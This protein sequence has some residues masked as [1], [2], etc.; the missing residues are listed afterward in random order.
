MALTQASVEQANSQVEAL[1]STIITEGVEEG[2]VSL[3]QGSHC[4]ELEQPG[5]FSIHI[6]RMW[7]LHSVKSATTRG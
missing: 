7:S 2:A 1:Y 5:T 3:T 6:A 4:S